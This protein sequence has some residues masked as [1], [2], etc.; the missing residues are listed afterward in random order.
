M[1][2]RT[3][4]RPLLAL[5]SLALLCTTA[6]AQVTVRSSS[7]GNQPLRINWRDPRTPICQADMPLTITE[8]G[9]Y[10]VVENLTGSSG[11]HGITIQADDVTID[12]NGFSLTG[13]TGA[14][15]GIHADLG[16]GPWRNLTVRNGADSFLAY[17][18]S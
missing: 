3:P 9:S 6:S 8:S 2:N 5:A 13:V 10:V 7:T 17:Y 16:T 12:L 14:L 1:S 4:L 15:D 11:S 18:Y